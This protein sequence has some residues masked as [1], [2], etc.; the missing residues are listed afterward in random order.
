[1]EGEEEEE[2]EGEEGEEATDSATTSSR[3]RGRRASYS[4]PGSAA[5]NGGHCNTGGSA[6]DSRARTRS[7]PSPGAARLTPGSAGEVVTTPVTRGGRGGGGKRG[8]GA[9]DVAGEVRVGGAGCLDDVVR[10][11]KGVGD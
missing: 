3:K 5:A 10:A 1:M 11:G 7:S 2:E 4:P 9:S 6:R 8:A